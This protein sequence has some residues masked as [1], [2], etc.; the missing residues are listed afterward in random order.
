M[1]EQTLNGSVQML[2]ELA[3]LANRKRSGGAKICEYV[4]LVA[5]GLDLGST[6]DIEVAAMLAQIGSMTIPPSIVEKSRAGLEL[7]PAEK[8]MVASVPEIGFRVLSQIPR[9]G[10]AAQIVLHQSEAPDGATQRI[11]PIKS[12]RGRKAATLLKILSDLVDLEAKG[13]AKTQAFQQMRASRRPF[14]GTPVFD[15]VVA[16]FLAQDSPARGTVRV[17]LKDLAPGQEWLSA[18]ETLDGRLLAPV[19]TVIS[20]MMLERFNNFAA[21]SGIKEPIY[22]KTKPKR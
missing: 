22:V 5:P 14:S 7:T 9:L 4:R 8:E 18:I 16:T 19:G 1:L 12:Q 6:W 3:S 2:T 10:P 13:V 20:P 11:E 21:H 17:P 15:A